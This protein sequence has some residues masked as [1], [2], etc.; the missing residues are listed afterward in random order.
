MNGPLSPK[1][2]FLAVEAVDIRLG[3]G[4]T[5]TRPDW[6]RAGYTSK[7][8]GHSCLPLRGCAVRLGSVCS[9]AAFIGIARSGLFQREGHSTAAELARMDG[10]GSW[11]VF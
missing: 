7:Q 10:G 4:R 3:V 6:R 1:Q 5:E 8:W 9:P 11:A 2:M